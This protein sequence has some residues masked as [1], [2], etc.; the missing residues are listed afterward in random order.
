M[1]SVSSLQTKNGIDHTG[2]AAPIDRAL[3]DLHMNLG[4]AH[5][6]MNE[7]EA[8]IS[9]VLGL[10]LTKSIGIKENL[11]TTSENSRIH[12]AIREEDAIVV[13]LQDRIRSLI[14]R[15]QL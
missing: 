14:G 6:L 9:P 1:D 4:D 5:Q 3:S 7:L 12:D 15:V 8:K 2:G 13:M 11:E 10:D